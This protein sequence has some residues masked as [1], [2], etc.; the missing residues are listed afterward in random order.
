MRN[1]KEYMEKVFKDFRFIRKSTK[2]TTQQYNDKLG[3]DVIEIW[4]KYGL[5]VRLRGI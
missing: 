2:R 3:E 4:E 1:N 5:A